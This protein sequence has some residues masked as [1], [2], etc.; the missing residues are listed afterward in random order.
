MSD[1]K[2]ELE[3]NAEAAG[4]LADLAKRYRL[5]GRTKSDLFATLSSIASTAVIGMANMVNLDDPGHPDCPICRVCDH[6][7]ATVHNDRDK[8]RDEIRGHGV[9]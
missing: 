1:S 7:S 2:A 4:M 8:A 9:H 3:A 5:A 6:I